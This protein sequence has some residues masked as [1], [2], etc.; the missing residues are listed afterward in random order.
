MYY[1]CIEDDKITSVLSY[2]PTV[3][4]SV[5]VYEISDQDHEFLKNRT[6]Y[7]SIEEKSVKPNPKQVMDE[8]ALEK[9]KDKARGNLSSTDWKVLRH[10]RE[11]TLNIPTTLSESQY[12][13]L[14]Y[15]REKWAEFIRSN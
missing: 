6:H 11:K 2:E 14:E 10:I 8:M 13:E 7:F 5:T 4:N 1:V 9:E 3:P 15:N 12:L